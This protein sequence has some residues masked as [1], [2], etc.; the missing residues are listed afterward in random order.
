[1]EAEQ[2]QLLA[3]DELFRQLVDAAPDAMVLVDAE[4]RIT[5][6]NLQA[7]S[8]FGYGRA[9]LVGQLIEVLIPERY[10]GGHVAH[11]SGFV[12]SPK[13]RPMGTG[14]ELFGLR[15]DGSEFPIEIS[16]SPLEVNGK[17]LV[18]SAIRDVTVRRRAEQKFRA[19]LEAAPD[20][21]I[22]AGPDGRIALVNAQA[23]RL[24]GY[25]RSELLGETIE[26]L[27]P[28]RFQR[29]HVGY[30]QKYVAEPKARSMG[31]GLNLFARRK[32]GSE[33]PVEISLS[34][35]ET[36]DG[37]LISSAIR[38]ISERR[39]TE[40][41]AK[42]ASERL[43]SAVESFHGALTLWDA[44][45]QLTLC[46]STSRALFAPAV[47]GPLI[48]TTFP[49]LIDSAIRHGLFG[50]LEHPT[51]FRDQ[52]VAYHQN[53]QGTFDLKLA[54]GGTLRLTS[55]RTLEG[56]V[57]ST[58]IDVSEEVQHEAELRQARSEA[59]AA[60]A[61]KSEFLSS[62][63]H[64]LRTPMNA[65][66][67]FAQLLQRDKRTPLSAAQQEKLGYVLQGGEHLLR[68]IDDILDLS[69]IE[70]GRIM[71]SPEPVGVNEVLLEVQQTLEPMAARA[72]IQLFVSTAPHDLS[73]V[74]AD[75]TRFKQILLNFGS[76]AVKYG[77][78]GGRVEIRVGRAD[79]RL[80]LSVTDDGIGIPLEKQ[81]K[82]FQ[83]FQRAGQE[84]GPIEGTGIG[85][86]ITKRLAELMGGTVGF[87]SEPGKGS[88][89]WVDLPLHKRSEPAQPAAGPVVPV[90]SELGGEGSD[91][92]IVYI[93]DNPSNIAFMRGV[94]DELP[95]VRLT[96]VPNAE[97]GIELVR[98]TLPRVV[99]MDINL[100]G[101]SGYEA[102]RRLREWP[103]TK[104]IPVIALTAAA[105]LGDRKR[106]SE[107][108]FYRYLTKPV[109]VGELLEAIEQLLTKA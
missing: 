29:A 72:G 71:I 66:L 55:R 25:T 103:E 85:L 43:L 49:E 42:L 20:A 76:N 12:R 94:L 4:G 88:E 53:P 64:E 100:P 14:L 77:R 28:E 33:F 61:A 108:G 107:A 89:F 18:A 74:R 105:M 81:D 32:D 38:D 67:G 56:G 69:R 102:T 90:T 46:N 96:A 22:I 21:M 86:S 97:V 11:R 91:I 13:L 5:L 17:K 19:L 62:M 52:L 34:P 39:Q 16:L 3:S 9:E 109:K 7:E 99:I 27:I 93:E 8:L 82:I 68:L 15:R 1:M 40:Q 104:H 6:V 26:R 47:E 58:A 73:Q 70:A 10:R 50:Q 37:L 101:M 87:R 83:P 106:L 51:E 65:I 79:Q 57:I 92:S 36:E 44:A 98:S 63:S 78:S 35:L 30:R 59:E 23:E 80:R 31:S 95:R 41:A 54:G 48:G 24:F 75:R 45:D 60:S 2:E 84:A